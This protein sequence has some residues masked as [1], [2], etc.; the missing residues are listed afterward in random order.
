MF[1]ATA[2]VP[3]FL[4]PYTP[5]APVTVGRHKGAFSIY[6][7]CNPQAGYKYQWGH[8]SSATHKRGDL[9][10]S[11]QNG[12]QIV[13]KSDPEKIATALPTSLAE[14]PDDWFVVGEFV[15]LR[16]PDEDYRRIRAEQAQRTLDALNGPTERFQDAASA[17]DAALGRLAPGAG[18]FFKGPD[19]GHNGY[20]AEERRRNG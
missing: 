13:K 19:H 15:L 17:G 2:A 12:W 3:S 11:L 8:A 1:K 10:S 20:Q 16:I 5:E 9:L 6:N 7:F 4:K 14:A 18:S